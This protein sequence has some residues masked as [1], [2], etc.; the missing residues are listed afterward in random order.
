VT[1]TSKSKFFSSEEATNQFYSTIKL[2]GFKLMMDYWQNKQRTEATIKYLEKYLKKT[3]FILDLACGY[4]RISIPLAKKGYKITGIDLMEE[5]IQA[6]RFFSFEQQ[7]NAEFTVGNMLHLPYTSEMFD[8]VI[9]LCLSFNHL[10]TPQDQITAINEIYRVLKKGGKGL[11]E[12]QNGELVSIRRELQ[13][14]ALQGYENVLIDDY[15]VAAKNAVMYNYVHT[16][17]TLEAV[18]KKTHFHTFLVKK[19]NF[20]M[21]RRLMIFLEKL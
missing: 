18:L 14:R 4:G 8:V 19:M 2:E 12:T 17:Q 16:K 5:L 1:A 21:R 3:D 7:I 10:L 13:K 6:A 20:G 11:I 9:C 15:S